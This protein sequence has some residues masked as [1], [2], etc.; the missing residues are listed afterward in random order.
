MVH[1]LEPV[2]YLEPSSIKT[3]NV[4]RGTVNLCLPKTTAIKSLLVCFE[5][6]IATKSHPRT[7]KTIT[8][9]YLTLYPA[10]DEQTGRP[11]IMSAGSTQFGFEMQTT[12]HL[13]E[14]ID[15]YKVRV[16]YHVSAIMEYYT[17]YRRPCLWF[18][19]GSDNT[20]TI[21]A[22][23]PIR[24]VRLPS[25]D[26]LLNISNSINSGTQN[27]AWLNYR[28]SIDKKSVSLGS[29]I[30]IAFCLEPVVY[31]SISIDRV[32]VQLLEKCDLYNHGLTKWSY[33]VHS[34]RP[35]NSNHSIIPKGKFSEPWEGT[36]IYKIPTDKTL[37]HSTQQHLDFHI[38]HMLFVSIE[39][40]A[41]GRVRRTVMFH[42]PI[43]LLS[44]AVGDLESL[45]L[46][47]YD[48]R[49][50]PPFD[51]A[52]NDWKFAGVHPPAYSDIISI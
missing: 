52:E 6:E 20:K 32:A 23:Q 27:S 49:P 4:I 11:L 40:S 3:N 21:T 28:I 48:T 38:S 33:L 46:P 50:P 24:V 15:C 30:S 9:E 43:D 39:F 10:T 14:T 25:F 35:C 51:S 45:K 17:D 22:K 5:G 31:S 47:T 1:L 19:S 34:I 16:N 13:P 8:R 41:P 42:A 12:S 2:I 36:I 7:V 29:L 37:V 18:C 26:T 44:E